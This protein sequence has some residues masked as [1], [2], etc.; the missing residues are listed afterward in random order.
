M[1]SGV[2]IPFTPPHYSLNRARVVDLPGI[3]MDAGVAG[4]TAFELLPAKAMVRF[5]LERGAEL[6][7]AAEQAADGIAARWELPRLIERLL[8][9]GNAAQRRAAEGIVARVGRNLGHVLLMLHR[10]DPVNR[11]ARPEWGDAEW[12]R[13]AAVRRVWLAGGLASGR[14]GAGIAAHAKAWLDAVGYGGTLE[15]AASAFAGDTALVGAARYLPPDAGLSLCCDF[16]QTSVKRGLFTVKDRRVIR[17]RPLP[18][19]AALE[20]PP[21]DTPA[22]ET[23]ELHRAFVVAT[24]RNA[25]GLAQEENAPG[26]AV[27]EIMLSLP[28][29]MDRGR[30][31]G[32]GS[33]STMSLLG[34]D[35]PA[36]LTEAISAGVGR[37]CH[38]RLI[39]DG[40]AA[41][42]VFAG[43]S[44]SAVIALG[45]ALGVGFPSD[46]AEPLLSIANLHDTR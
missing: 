8:I 36:L 32:P 44:A 4:K 43:Q 19:A 21:A 22:L 27:S 3:P 13:W 38:A 28:C 15:I 23:A 14:M 35:A 17:Y 1:T 26:A 37:P 18:R 16:G 25:L 7:L 46:D 45:S 39:H 24:V 5:A 20:P 31:L 40:T 9:E 10:G 41:A 42:A 11:A 30:L 33:Y 6:G 2:A 12:A 34:P 29:Y